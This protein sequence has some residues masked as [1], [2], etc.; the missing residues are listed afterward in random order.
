MQHNLAFSPRHTPGAWFCTHPSDGKRLTIGRNGSASVGPGAHKEQG[1]KSV[2]APQHNPVNLAKHTAA[3]QPCELSAR[4]RVHIWRRAY[5]SICHTRSTGIC[6]CAAAQL[7]GTKPAP[8][9]NTTLQSRPS[10]R[11]RGTSRNHSHTTIKSATI[12]QQTVRRARRLTHLPHKERSG[13][14]E[15]C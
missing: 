10:T 11:L 2:S 14:P 5:P 3:G 8:R 7:E 13:N 9:R 1:P 4:F 15:T 6:P 12:P